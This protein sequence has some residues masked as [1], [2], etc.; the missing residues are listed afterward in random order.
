M[1]DPP[2]DLLLRRAAAGDD[3]AFAIF[4]RRW[5]PMIVG[6]H[7]RR[8]QRREV[9][10]DL[11]AETFAAV[12]TGLASFDPERGPVGA[13]VFGIAQNKLTDSLRRGRVEDAAR[14][15]LGREPIVLED[16]ALDRVEELASRSDERDVERA[17]SG[18]APGD[19]AVVLARV[20]DERTY[21]ELARELRC[22]EA[23]VRQRVHRGLR[24][25]RSRLEEQ[26]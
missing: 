24:R 17:L 14:R 11:A 19:R 15:R 21:A 25:L 20:V 1:A 16:A 3:D 7:L 12:V 13:W 23:V 18:L 10:F 9:A 5:L 22:S 4:Y 26:A 2:D 8:T 6:F